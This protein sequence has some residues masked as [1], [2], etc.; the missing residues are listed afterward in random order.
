MFNHFV[1]YPIKIMLVFLKNFFIFFL[2]FRPWYVL[3][4][5]LIKKEFVFIL[6]R[7]GSMNSV[8][9]KVKLIEIAKE[10]I[11]VTISRLSSLDKVRKKP[12]NLC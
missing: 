2:Y 1:L 5:N 8:I 6:D 7:S 12:I 11:K 3:A 10:A 4:K 9:D